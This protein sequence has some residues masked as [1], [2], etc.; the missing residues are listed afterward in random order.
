MMNYRLPNYFMQDGLQSYVLGIRGCQK[1]PRENMTAS[2]SPPLVLDNCGI[3]G[4]SAA[5]DV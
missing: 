4:F 2:K 5:P 1:I 3:E